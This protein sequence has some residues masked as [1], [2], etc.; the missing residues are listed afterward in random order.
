MH[1]PLAHPIQR[2]F[3]ARRSLNVGMTTIPEKAKTKVAT[4]LDEITAQRDHLR[5]RTHLA[6][7]EIREEWE[8]L[9]KRWEHFRARASVVK[10]EAGDSAED[11]GEALSL[12]AGELR[13]GYE[14]LRALL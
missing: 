12:V 7:A 8:A 1:G 5:V 6:R 2:R 11:V 9:E 4:L 14:R 3:L 10:R 13:R